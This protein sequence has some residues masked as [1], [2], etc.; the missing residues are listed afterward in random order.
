MTVIGLFIN[1]L[2]IVGI[3]FALTKI[4]ENMSIKKLDFKNIDTKNLNFKD[5]DINTLYNYII[6]IINIILLII[7]FIL[8]LDN[9]TILLK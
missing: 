8:V 6:N 1:A 2:V 7:L 3:I 4:I 9:C 5:K